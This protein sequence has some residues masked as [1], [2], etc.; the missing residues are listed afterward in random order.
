MLNTVNNSFPIFVLL[1]YIEKI[2][3]FHF[4]WQNHVKKTLYWIYMILRLNEI[5]K[6]KT[7]LTAQL[8]QMNIFSMFCASLFTNVPQIYPLS[9]KS[10]FSCAQ[11][12]F[13]IT[14]ILGGHWGLRGYSRNR[15]QQQNK[16]SE[17]S[18]FN[19]DISQSVWLHGTSIDCK[20][21][22]ALFLNIQN[23]LC[24]TF[25]HQHTPLFI[26]RKK[27]YS[28]SDIIKSHLMC[29]QYALSHSYSLTVN[30]NGCS[31]WWY[32]WMGEGR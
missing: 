28:S 7:F 1:K 19:C 32:L 26:I 31:I 14:E 17:Y 5:F 18:H 8:C 10:E 12:G 27:L 3:T 4:I 9:S 16:N 30:I 23:W 21:P 13:V 29:I 15:T 11:H 2:V 25:S 24:L 6:Q 20:T 22:A